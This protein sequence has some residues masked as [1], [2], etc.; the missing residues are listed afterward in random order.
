[1]D[2][3]M[4]IPLFAPK[5]RNTEED[6]IFTPMATSVVA[7]A[8]IPQFPNHP[9]VPKG[10]IDE[11]K[12]PIQTN[13]FYANWL[14]AEQTSPIYTHPYSLVVQQGWQP[15]LNWGMG[16]S[17][18]DAN[19]IMFAEGT[20]PVQFY[21]HPLTT[22]LIISARELADHTRLETTNLSA[23]FILGHLKSQTTP[24]ISF[25]CYQG[26]GFV[27]AIYTNATANIQ[28]K[29]LYR[30]V[31]GPI[32]VNVGVKYRLTLEDD[33]VWLMYVVPSKGYGAAVFHLEDSGNFVG[34]PYWSGTVQI[35]KNPSGAD[36]EAVYDKA[37]GSHATKVHINAVT[38]TDGRAAKY[39]LSY[40]IVGTNPHLLFALPHHM[41]S[42]DFHTSGKKTCLKMRTRT[43]G[44]ATGL[45]TDTLAMIETDLPVT[46]G[47]A[48]WSPGKGE[49]LHMPDDAWPAVLYALQREIPIAPTGKLESM[50][51]TGKSLAKYASIVWI[52]NEVVK[53]P[54][55]ALQSLN[56]LKTVYLKFVKNWQANSLVYD[57]RWKGV[58]ESLGYR[59]AQQ[60]IDFGN[61]KYNDHH[62]HWGYFVYTAAVIATC[63][64]NWLRDGSNYEWVQMLVK[65]FA[66]G[67]QEDPTYPFSRHF[68]WYHG[69]SWA[70]GLYHSDDGK[71]Q[72]STSEDGF[73]SYAL[74]LWGRAI[75]DSNMESRGNLMLAIQARSFQHYFYMQNNNSVHPSQF[76]GN[77]IAGIMFENK[78]DH[79]TYF[80]Q[81][82]EFVS[83]IHMLP[84]LPYLAY[85][86]KHQFVKEEWDTYFSNN[87]VNNIRGGWRG[88]LYAN[89]ALIDPKAAWQFFLTGV[90]GE[91]H[92]E[93]LEDG[94]SMTWLLLWTAALGGAQE[95]FW[96][97]LERRAWEIFAE[98]RIERARIKA[99]LKKERELRL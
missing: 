61:T 40:T 58:V 10:V 1:M 76:I 85:I 26:M 4:R 60:D 74:K 52:A 44:M 55:G 57:T 33:T 24:V 39:L 29:K 17:H 25:P 37:A 71:D 83:G 49:I 36:G 84:S 95:G 22:S 30:Q 93:Y 23:F 86:R 7:P 90:Y 20:P 54:I 11:P 81:D 35:A 50:Y 27:T 32:A 75:G 77:K 34:P 18:M 48:P 46:L 94:Q 70:K 67:W 82:A 41:D 12:K 79:T 56:S 78:A 31:E 68:D 21:T 16:I 88:V 14:F 66:N 43:K 59:A 80:G 89:L 3:C 72:E 96:R 51:Y 87:R 92:G 42:L 19:D 6:T 63:D 91:W 53:E 9:I 2:S 97:H 64:P 28:S 38:T 8:E 65:D 15:A 13:K 99:D 73:A 62:S 45:L 5:L 98:R 47:F 69:H